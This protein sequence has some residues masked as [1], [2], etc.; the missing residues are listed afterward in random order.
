MSL[1]PL[2]PEQKVKPRY[3][4]LRMAAMFFTLLVPAGIYLPYFPLWLEANNFGPE[5]IAMILSG[6]IFLRVLTTPLFTALADKARDRADVYIALVLASVVLSAG[7]FLTP[8]YAIV[9]TVSLALTVVWTPHSP[10]ADSIALSGVRRF[11][12]N[13][14]AMRIWGSIS[15]LAA[16]LLGGV[17]LA[18]MGVEIVPAIV[19]AAFCVA[20]LTGLF[21]PR[22]GR[23][24]VSSPLSVVDIQQS[25][26]KLATPYF[27][28]F[29]AGTG[30][31]IG[32]HGFMYGFLSIYLKS[33]GLDDFVIGVLWAFGV[34]CEVV[35]F[36]VFNSLFGRLPVVSVMILAAAGAVIR[37]ILYPLVWPLGLGLSGL[38]AVQAL[39]AFSTALVIIGVQNMIAESVSD[40]RTGAAQ[41]IAYFANGFCMAVVTLVSGPLYERFGSGGFFAMIPVALAGLLMIVVAG[42]YRPAA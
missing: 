16:N 3:F 30:I 11:G 34:V 41:G 14:T 29:A 12:A 9:L 33:L 17:V 15:F 28:F 22:L 20:L 8:T 35:M 5:D 19:F 2:S 18:G 27:L 37:W 26:P 24:R 39:H 21:A 23:P 36:T 40:E 6:P 25:G 42:R 13:Y 31:I 10:L 7:Y 32:S 4:E 38:F 1:P